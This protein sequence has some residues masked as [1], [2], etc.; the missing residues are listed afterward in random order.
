MSKRQE[1]EE[2]IAKIQ[3]QLNICDEEEPEFTEDTPVVALKFKEDEQLP[4]TIRHEGENVI[5]EFW[6]DV[7]EWHE[8]LSRKLWI[9][10]CVICNEEGD[11]DECD[12]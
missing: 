3:Q 10:P 7:D 11:C 12:K 2:L 6:G 1:L 9:H 4:M 8:T 5:I